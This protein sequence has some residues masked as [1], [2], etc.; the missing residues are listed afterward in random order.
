MISVLV[1]LMLISSGLAALCLAEHDGDHWPIRDQETIQKTLPLSGEPGRLVID[2]IDGYV[3]VTA[4]SGSQVRVTAHKVIRAESDSDLQQAKS[5][6]N[7]QISESARL[8][9]HLLRRAMAL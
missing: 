2:N 8:R 4:S 5:E 9:N 7:L 6:V 1:R 3:H